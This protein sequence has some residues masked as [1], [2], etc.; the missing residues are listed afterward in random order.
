MYF[1][2]KQIIEASFT[3]IQ[4]SP[5]GSSPHGHHPITYFSPP[6]L[7]QCHPKGDLVSLSPLSQLRL[8]FQFTAIRLLQPRCHQCGKSTVFILLH[9]N[10]WL[11]PSNHSESM[12]KHFPASTYTSLAFLVC[13]LYGY[14]S[15]VASLLL[16]IP[17]MS[18]LKE[19]AVT[20]SL[21]HCSYSSSLYSLL[22]PPR[23]G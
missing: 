18:A 2:I 11:L 3:L 4:F 19:W 12:A 10:H 8:A 6:L 20:H 1:K 23:T 14:L 5:P 9:Q 15:P 22:C 21:T 16:L 17:S 7:S 13:L